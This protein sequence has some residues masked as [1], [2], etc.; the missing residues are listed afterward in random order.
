MPPRRRSSGPW[1]RLL[2]QVLVD[3]AGQRG[4][5]LDV[6]GAEQ[7]RRL[8]S[9]LEL[10]L[11]GH[12]VAQF[13]GALPVPLCQRRQIALAEAAQFHREGGLDQG[14]AHADAIDIALRRSCHAHLGVGVPPAHQKS[15]AGLE[16]PCHGQMHALVVVG[17]PGQVKGV[18]A[19]RG[20]QQA[21]TDG[22]EGLPVLGTGRIEPDLNRSMAA[23]PSPGSGI[24][25]TWSALSLR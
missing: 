3:A 7:A 21:H 16:H 25:Y 23:Q 9:I 11:P 2:D 12:A 8:R 13:L 4:P 1:P 10:L 17:A 20:Q 6:A 24:A 5:Q 15:G 18:S 14:D 22:D 19:A